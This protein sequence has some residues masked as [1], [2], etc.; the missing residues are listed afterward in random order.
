M[1]DI[2]DDL[3]DEYLKLTKEDIIELWNW[4]IISIDE[5]TKWKEIS[6]KEFILD[7]VKFINLMKSYKLFNRMILT[8]FINKKKIVLKTLINNIFDIIEL[9]D[10]DLMDKEQNLIILEI[11]LDMNK[12][13]NV[14]F[15]LT[16]KDF[17]NLLL[18]KAKF[19]KIK[20]SWIKISLFNSYIKDCEWNVIFY[21]TPSETELL[22][23]IP[24]N[25]WI[26]RDNLLKI[27]E[28]LSLDAMHKTIT[29]FRKKIKEYN[30]DTFIN[31]E[32]R[33]WERM[34]FKN[35]S[36]YVKKDKKNRKI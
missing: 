34:Y 35:G 6:K 10:K 2:S 23:S 26:S 33:K 12:T 8:N 21:M 31:I 29:R 24:K 5:V 7:F 28:H 17:I 22:R 19:I 3:V 9:K 32:Y 1:S 4:L 20:P 15:W 18:N 14:D 27:T 11:L 16:V 30:V 25:D 36:Y 13:L